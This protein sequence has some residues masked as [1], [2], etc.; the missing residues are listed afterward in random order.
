MIKYMITVIILLSSISV[1]AN[2]KDKWP[3]EKKGYDYKK[4][5]K[6]HKRA[7]DFHKHCRGAM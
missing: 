4:L 3:K 2:D 5:H 6:A 1:S 7:K